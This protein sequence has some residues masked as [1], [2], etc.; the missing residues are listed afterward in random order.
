MRSPTTELPEAGADADQLIAAYAAQLLARHQGELPAIASALQWPVSA[1]RTL[2][3]GGKSAR[4]RLLFG[5]ARVALAL[6]RT[7]DAIAQEMARSFLPSACVLGHA[8]VRTIATRGLP[9]AQVLK[10]L[11]M[12]E[13]ALTRLLLGRALGGLPA[14]ARSALARFLGLPDA[15]VQQLIQESLTRRRMPTRELAL[16]GPVRSLAEALHDAF[17]QEGLS[18]TAWV[19]R[20]RFSNH[21]IRSLVIGHQPRTPQRS[22]ARLAA[23]LGWQERQVLAGLR[24]NQPFPPPPHREV[25]E[26]IARC[27]PGEGLDV[28]AR[29]FAMTRAGVERLCARQDLSR[30]STRTMHRIRRWLGL[31]WR[32]FVDLASSQQRTPSSELRCATSFT[33]VDQGELVMIRLWRKAKPAVRELALQALRVA[34]MPASPGRGAAGAEGVA[35]AG[36][37]VHGLRLAAG[38]SALGAVR[39]AE[40]SRF[41]ERSRLAEQEPS[42][43]TPPAYDTQSGSA[44]ADPLIQGP[45]DRARGRP[46]CELL[47]EAIDRAEETPTRWGMRHHLSL[48]PVRTL[49]VG[50]RV[51]LG[52]ALQDKIGAALGL[53]A[54]EVRSGIAAGIPL[55]P[56]PHHALFAAV[57]R[58]IAGRPTPLIAREMAM[59]RSSYDRMVD[60]GD[61]GRLSGMSVHRLRV[62]MGWSWEALV[63]HALPAPH[64]ELA[65][66]LDPPAAATASE[67]ED[68]EELALIRSWRTAAVPARDQALEFLAGAAL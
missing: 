51:P 22:L 47:F 7:R 4:W 40:R 62:W 30:T 49:L 67:R 61:L 9:L 42:H 44:L 38:D 56:P 36:H 29:A 64:D 55:P 59:A 3:R 35:D 18:Q 37:V 33:P 21:W 1:V 68:A 65:H 57:Q 53:T 20:H 6:G 23:A 50:E 41:A 12:S 26:R 60:L 13:A 32:E 39:C 27:A 17:D 10:Q 16:V 63:R 43:A 34:A 52:A 8:V 5:I 31:S 25:F 46:L 54:A 14:T 66:D 48:G 24:L 45:G 15:Q 11:G 2:M 19:Q 58:R 28:L